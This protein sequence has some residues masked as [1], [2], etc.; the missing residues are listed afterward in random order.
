VNHAGHTPY[1][2]AK[3]QVSIRILVSTLLGFNLSFVVLCAARATLVVSSSCGP[4]GVAALPT[5]IVA[6][7]EAVL[8]PLAT[9]L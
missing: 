2:V 8:L 1:D 6:A 3:Q 7:V 4:M 5:L 9:G